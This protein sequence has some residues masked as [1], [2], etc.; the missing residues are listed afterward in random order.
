M[1]GFFC[2]DCD[3]ECGSEKD[4]KCHLKGKIHKLIETRAIETIA[5]LDKIYEKVILFLN[6]I[7]IEE[8]TSTKLKKVHHIGPSCITCL[9][10]K[11][12][13]SVRSHLQDKKSH[14]YTK[15]QRKAEK[16]MVLRMVQL[17]Y[18]NKH[19]VKLIFT[20]RKALLI[21]VF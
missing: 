14:L 4:L 15:E 2:E 16:R 11:S 5:N 18:E 13:K 3:I 6:G 19:K 20:V 10:K 12:L 7:P 8:C 1:G 17:N 9:E 21:K